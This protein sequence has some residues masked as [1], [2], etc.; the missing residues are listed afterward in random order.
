MEDADKTREQLLDEIAQLRQRIQELESLTGQAPPPDCT[1]QRLEGWQQQEELQLVTD[2]VPALISFVDAQGR[3]RFNNRTYED[4]IG[5]P[6]SQ[7]YGMHLREV[8][9]EAGWDSIRPWVERAL[10]GEQVSFEHEIVYPVIGKRYV[11]V[12]YIPRFGAEGGVLGFVVLVQ[13]I[14]ERKQVEAALQQSEAMAKL[15]E[16]IAKARAEELEIFMETV[17]AS[18]WIAH[19]P[20]C[21]TI[22]V[23]RAAYDLMRLSPGAVMTA[24]PANGEYPFQFKIQ[25]QGQDLPLSELP[26]QRA[27]RTGQPVEAEFEFVF[28]EDDVRS[29]Y[30]KAVPLRDETQAVRGVIGA[31]IDLTERKRTEAALRENQDRLTLALDAARMGSWDWNLQTNQ[32]VWTP[33]HEVIFGYEP[34]KPQRTYQEWAERIHPEDLPRVEATIQATMAEQRGYEDE[35]RVVWPDGSL[36]W[37]SSYGRFEYDSGGKPVRMLGML[38]DITARKQAEAVLR[39]NELIFRTLAD[40][41]PQMFWITRPDGYHEYFNQRWY[42]YTGAPLEQAQ[43]N[44]WQEILHPEDVQRTIDLWQNSLK[45]GKLY[46]IEYRLRQA[47]DGEYRWHLGRALPLHDQNG[48]ILKWFG[49]CTDIHDQKLAIEERAQALERERAARLELENA[50]RMKDEF[51]AVLSH[52]LRSPLNAILGWSRLL[53]ARKLD[54]GRTEQALA[55]IERNAQAQTQ[56]IEDLLDISRIIQGQMHLNLQPTPLQPTIEAALDTVRPMASIKSIQIEWWSNADFAVVSGD[57]NRLQQVVWNLLSNAVKFTPEGGQVEV[58]LE[59]KERWCQIIVSDTGKGISADF[60]PYV[61]DRF[62]LADATTTRTQGGLGLGLAIVRN[63]VELHGGTVEVTS[64]GEGQGAI[65][66]VQLPLLRDA[67]SNQHADRPV[68]ALLEQAGLPLSGLSIL[69]VDDETDTREFLKAALEQYGAQVMLAT[70]S[71]EALS[72]LQTEKPDLLLSDIGMPDEDG[73][74]LIEKVRSLSPAEGGHTPAAAL[75]AYARESDQL[76][77]LAAGFQGHLSK[78][79][80]PMQLL[81]LVLKLADRGECLPS[82]PILQ[83]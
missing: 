30:G 73:Y 52:E 74:T 80:E 43:G 67:R 57:A 35:Y 9:G 54:A 76:Q 33:Y 17:P 44:G 45:T 49:S 51:L 15:A 78:P 29:I 7:F 63:L 24:T 47:A 83:G 18:V 62:R 38:F 50:S 71:Q 19:D 11:N 28:A 31:F 82:E 77:A 42:H 21:H 40:T 5:Y 69:V 41:M 39:H 65:F 75:T 20:Q 79:I 23:N 61:F 59:Q 3:Y 70:S 36:H 13:D 64:P 68:Q 2:A 22:T 72:L 1:E 55:S 58:R 6:R 27:G 12:T 60:L 32:V 66:T 10:Q 48:Q 8:F 16:K 34:G 46:E 56:L 4:W 26:M 14:T 25:Q 53:R 37:V 81:T